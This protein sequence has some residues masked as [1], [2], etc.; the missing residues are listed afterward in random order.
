MLKLIKKF[1]RSE[2]EI[3]FEETDPE[4][5]A[6]WLE[7][8]ISNLQFNDYLQ[9]YFQ[10]ITELKSQL[11]E[12]TNSLK[13]QEISEHD[14]KQV[15]DRVKNIVIGHKNHYVNEIERFTEKLVIVEAGKSINSYQNILSFNEDLDK[16]LEELAKRTAKSYQAAQHLF[17]ENVES[18]FKLLGE[19]NKTVKGFEQKA[20][21][22]K[23]KELQEVEDLIHNLNQ[24]IE[25]KKD[26]QEQIRTKEKI[27]NKLDEEKK[28]AENRLQELKRS[29]EHK[30]FLKLKEEKEN[31]EQKY[32]NVEYQI[33]S[34]FSKLNKALKKY[35]RIS[36]ENKLIKEYLGNGVG[37]FMQDSELKIIQV[38]DG[39]KN[40]LD[41]LQF[42]EKHKNNFSELI[43][44]SNKGC[45]EKLQ[46]E[47]KFLEK[48]R[49]EL[50]EKLR[51][52]NMKN[53]LEK[54]N[55]EKEYLNDKSEKIT[56]EISDLKS[57]SEKV[58]NENNKN[59]LAGKVKEIFNVE[60]RIT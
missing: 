28:D 12:K 42:D 33:F 60:L 1:F 59:E 7:N 27:A 50:D 26:L 8:K 23:V 46:S 22:Y 5:L 36:L 48:Q 30:K 18:I 6:R 13:S 53:E 41:K 55:K 32:R 15:E 10:H 19:L 4:N 21:E 35:E 20:G 47:I 56:R 34:F 11:H 57:T 3:A 25:K 45:L 17:F 2:K 39:L 54:T 51:N 38:L 44:R 52:N 16:E 58:N 37:T 40:N 24:E 29:E 9:R 49:S 14:Q 43:D 31:I